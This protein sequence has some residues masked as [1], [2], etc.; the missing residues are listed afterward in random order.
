MGR[1]L[2]TQDIFPGE[3]IR[4]I[5]ALWSCSCW[6]PHLSHSLTSTRTVL[7]YYRRKET[8]TVPL[9]SLF[10]FKS[11]FPPKIFFFFPFPNPG[12]FV[13]ASLSNDDGNHA[14]HLLSSCY[15]LVSTLEC[16]LFPPHSPQHGRQTRLLFASEKTEIHRVQF[17]QGQR[18]CNRKASTCPLL[19]TRAFGAPASQE[20]N[21]STEQL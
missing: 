21:S 10:F 16:S 20:M 15:I 2:L 9:P 1:K 7:P 12:F 13:Y 3:A 19:K 17:A 8:I 4:I 11:Y 18:V 6:S 5:T 14:H